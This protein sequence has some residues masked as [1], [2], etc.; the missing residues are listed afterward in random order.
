MPVNLSVVEEEIIPAL[1]H[2][3]DMDFSRSIAEI[4]LTPGLFLAPDLHL[5]KSEEYK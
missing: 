2:R 4:H 1:R 5:S 3:L